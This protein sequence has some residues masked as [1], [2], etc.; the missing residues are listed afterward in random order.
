MDTRK[1]QQGF[2]LI[3]IIAVIVL[4]GVLAAVLV[5]RFTSMTSDARQQALAQA[6]AEG[7]SRVN[8]G[9]ASYIL[10]N[11]GVPTTW[12]LANLGIAAGETSGDYTLAYAVDGG[13]VNIT[14]GYTNT[15]AYTQTLASSAVL[16][17]QAT[18]ATGT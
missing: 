1:R 5:P 16:P 2:T 7:Q 14:A 13:T 10:R 9:A 15:A 3:E 18:T 12:S 6:I 17:T 8:Q 11:G 4:L